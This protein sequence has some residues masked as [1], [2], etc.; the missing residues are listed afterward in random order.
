MQ[1]LGGLV[2]IAALILGG[3]ALM[4]L[5]EKHDQIQQLQ[6]A[7]QELRDRLTTMETEVRDALGAP[8]DPGLRAADAPGGAASSAG[9]APA[10]LEGRPT[11]PIA[12]L[13]SLEKRV[14]AQDEE[15]AKLRAEKAEEE[16]A[17]RTVSRGM[18]NLRGKTF[19]GNVAMAAKALDLTDT[20]R[21]DMQDIIDRAKDELADLYKIENDEGV[22]WN[23]VRKPKMVE[24]SGFS[25]AMPNMAKI[26]KFKKGRIPGSSETYGEAETRIRKD[27]FARMR[28]LLTPEQAGTWDKASKEPLLPGGSGMISSVAFL[29]VGEGD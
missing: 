11:S 3:Y 24:G 13:A 17:A 12:R 27:A 9:A 4:Q 2:A 19:Y 1:N 26:A 25:I 16:N 6:A 18:P 5:G 29:D 8:D 21:T 20:Q 23:E 7:N 15:L 28:N 14:K 10:G 22:T